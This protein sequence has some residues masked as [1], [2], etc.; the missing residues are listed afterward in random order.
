MTTSSDLQVAKRSTTDVRL[1]I[2]LTIVFCVI[3]MS[4]LALIWTPYPALKVSVGPSLAPISSS[5]PFGTDVYGRDVL[6]RVMA[7]GLPVIESCVLA[8]IV[9]VPFGV[10][11]GTLSAWMKDTVVDFAVSLVIDTL[12]GFPALLLAIT[13]VTVLGASTFVA[14]ISV[15]IA[16]IPSVAR[17]IRIRT[18][19]IIGRGF[20][21]LAR[22]YGY[23]RRSITL[24]HLLP[25]LIGT[26]VNQAMLGASLTVL[27]TAA[28]S[29]LGLGTPPPTPTWGEMIQ[30]A[31]GYVNVDPK[32]LIVP[33]VFV[34]ATIFGFNLLAD[35]FSSKQKRARR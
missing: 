13:L 1:V 10:F 21:T 16:F 2:G 32:L 27:A 3:S 18:R 23:S 25:N 12:Y 20:I 34:A 6:S 7:G 26:I 19:E 30:E 5:H 15:G 4:L 24:G 22:T 33:A 11:L 14:A 31:Q 17:V 8:L 28:L 35:H 29:Y 9:S